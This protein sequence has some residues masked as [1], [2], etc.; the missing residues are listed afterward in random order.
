MRITETAHW[1]EWQDWVNPILAEPF[2]LAEGRL[3][4][5][6]RPGCGIEWDEQAVRRFQLAT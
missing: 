5:P 4:V 1:L 6:E 2:E 3:T